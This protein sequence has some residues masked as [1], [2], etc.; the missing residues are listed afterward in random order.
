MSTVFRGNKRTTRERSWV[1]RAIV[2]FFH[3]H[4][5]L[6]DKNLVVTSE[7]FHINSKTIYHWF[8]KEDVIHKWKDIVLGLTAQMVLEA[9]PKR[10]DR[11][12]YT[13]RFTEAQLLQGIPE[14]VLPSSCAVPLETKT[15]VF[16]IIGGDKNTITTHQKQRAFA[17]SNKEDYVYLKKQQ[18]RVH[19]SK[20]RTTKFALEETWLLDQIRSA[21]ERR[22]LFTMNELR[23]MVYQQFTQGKLYECHILDSKSDDRKHPKGLNQ[24]L[25]RTLEH[26]K[27]TPRKQ[28]SIL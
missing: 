2:L 23:N 15:I 11:V 25:R 8:H 16:P 17:Q 4:P 5:N 20:H 19:T 21:K 3:F 22:I 24:W 28:P 10:S 1:E 7:T 6:S 12:M 27:Y 14:H 18:K 9:L 13:A 26:A